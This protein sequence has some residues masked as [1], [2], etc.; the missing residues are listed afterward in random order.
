MSQVQRKHLDTLLSVS[1]AQAV[2]SKDYDEVLGWKGVVSIRRHQLNS[3]LRDPQAT[4]L[5]QE[6]RKGHSSITRWKAG[7]YENRLSC[8]FLGHGTEA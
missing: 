4:P 1:R 5:A 8:S 7:L 6:W 2:A 3:L